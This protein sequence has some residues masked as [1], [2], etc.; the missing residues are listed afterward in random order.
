MI[1]VDTELAEEIKK[2]TSAI[3]ELLKQKNIRTLADN[4]FELLKKGETSLEE[5]YPMLLN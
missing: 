5:V 1:P 4:A 3:N 2:G